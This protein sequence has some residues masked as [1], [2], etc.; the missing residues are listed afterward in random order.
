[1]HSA[2]HGAFMSVTCRVCSQCVYA[3]AVPSEA[4]VF[5]DGTSPK[6]H[7]PLFPSDHLVWISP[8]CIGACD[9]TEKFHSPRYSPLF[10]VVLPPMPS[11]IVPS[12][13]P[14]AA[15]LP[16]PSEISYPLPLVP[17]TMLD[18]VDE[19]VSF[20]PDMTALAEAALA[21]LRAKRAE[22]EREIADMI[23]EKQH[24][25]TRLISDARLHVRALGRTLSASRTAAEPAP[26]AKSSRSSQHRDTFVRQQRRAAHENASSSAL[27][28]SFARL[29]REPAAAPAA[30]TPPALT[31]ISPEKPKKL[32][33]P[34][35]TRAKHVAFAPD[36]DI[37]ADGDDA[38]ADTTVFDIDEDLEDAGEGVSA[39]FTHASEPAEAAPQAQ[40]AKLLTSG[41]ATSFST[42][43]APGHLLQRHRTEAKPPPGPYDLPSADSAL[44]E[45][46][47]TPLAGTDMEL[48]GALGAHMPSH[49]KYLAHRPSGFASEQRYAPWKKSET[50]FA[51]D[52]LSARSVP[53]RGLPALVQRAE[54][55][56][57]E[58]K[59]SL[60]YNEK[61]YVPSL[62]QAVGEKRSSP[63]P[64]SPQ[65]L[66]RGF[67]VPVRAARPAPSL[68]PLPLVPSASLR[69][70]PTFSSGPRAL[71]SI[72]G[73]QGLPPAPP[74]L[75]TY[76]H[77]LQNLKLSKR[78]GW[79]H[80]HVPSPESIADHM[81]RMAM[82]AM[83]LEGV[84]VRKCVMMALVHDLAEAKVGDL[85]PHDGVPKDEKT[86]RE[87]DAM[88]Y[89]TRDLLQGMRAGDDIHALWHEYEERKT[90][91]A[92][93]VKDLDCFELCLQTYEYEQLHGVRD[94][95]QFWRGAAPKISHPQVRSW[96]A[97]L[98]EERRAL[99]R[100]RDV[101]YDVAPTA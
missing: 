99:W 87:R 6:Q 89:F 33:A 55:I 36:S 19:A 96:L 37:E 32:A 20:H 10:D 81:Y 101:L 27:S 91:E 68:P 53:S 64:V 28:A 4:K 12:A 29:G 25:L 77:Y 13:A 40:V 98:L 8:A 11:D 57:S 52:A 60:P 76:M 15:P 90:P 21:R 79:F 16:D 83:L 75:L 73:D 93:L 51:S 65:R 41:L 56:D 7:D 43:D 30:P 71:E 72:T 42:I 100:S 35:S 97:A 54:L 85:T 26:S 84:D 95:Q 44:D 14:P 31:P 58:P 9:I 34:S 46:K 50:R 63:S 1:M 24:E 45:V 48:L 18:Q 17:G 69:L 78:T 66:Q 80:H 61:M 49:R 62:L 86:Q 74:S 22:S 2:V 38:G 92:R 3:A 23:R 82:L 59:T 94:L 70:Q 88:E 47:H 67:F 39:L 5:G